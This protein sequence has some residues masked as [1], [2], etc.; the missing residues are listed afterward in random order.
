MPW[1]ENFSLCGKVGLNLREG[2]TS[3]FQKFFSLRLLNDIFNTTN[4]WIKT[5]NNETLKWIEN[6]KWTK[7]TEIIKWT[8]VD[9]NDYIN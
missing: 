9:M 8:K 5:S 3:T 7:V 6:K 4:Q 1:H 2:S